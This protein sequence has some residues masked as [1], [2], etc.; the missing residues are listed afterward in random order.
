MDV[1]SQAI[2][3]LRYLTQVNLQTQWR[4]WVED[5]AFAAIAQAEDWCDRVTARSLKEPFA[6]LNV[7]GHIPWLKGQQSVWLSQQIAIPEH[8]HN[9]PLEGLEVRLALS[10]WAEVAEIFVDGQR[11]QEGDLFDCSTRIL[12]SAAAQPGDVFSVTLHLVSPG[13]DDGALVR[14]YLMFET[15]ATAT[16]LDPGFIADELA[17][18]QSYLAKFEPDRLPEMEQAISQIDWTRVCDRSAFDQSLS[19]LRRRLIPLANALKQRRIVML[20]HAHLDMA[21]LWPVAETWEAAERTFKSALGLQQDFPELIFC[22]S[23]P[24]LYAW[25]ENHRP[26]LFE[27][28]QQ[29]VKAGRWEIVAGLWVEPELNLIGGE[30]IV[31]QVLYGQRYVQQTFGQLNRIAWLPDTFGFCWQLPQI[32]KQGGVDF[33]VTQKLRW[34]DTT[35]FPY[36]AFWWQAPDGTAIFSL[37][38]A[39]IGQDISPI[40]MTDYAWEW[41]Q[42]TQL[43]DSLWL[44]GVGDHGGGPTRDMLETAQRWQRSPFFPQLEFATA[45]K[46]LQQI[47]TA[48]LP[49]AFPVWKD[50]LYLEFH[51]GCYTTHADQKRWNRHCE[52]LL[53][54]AELYAS[55]AHLITGQIYPKT[56]LEMAWKLVL[57][58]QFHDILP[59]SSIPQVFVDAN[60]DWEAA[61]QLASAI[62]EN[63]L[64]A[65]AAQIRVPELPHPEAQAIVVFNSLN[66]S[67]SEVVSLTLPTSAQ[68]WKIY[69]D[70]GQPVQT[71]FSIPERCPFMRSASATIE[72]GETWMEVSFLAHEIP[73]VG[74]RFFWLCPSAE[75]PDGDWK[76]P[77]DFGLENEFLQVVIDAQTGNL[78]R[79]FDKSAQRDVLNGAGNQLQAF[80]D[81]GQYWDAWNIDPNYAQHPLPAPQLEAIQWLEHGPLRQRIRVTHT[82]GASTFCQD[83]VLQVGAAVLK[84]ETAVDWQERHVVVKAAFPLNVDADYATYETPFAA[85]TRPA[86]PVEPQDKAKWEVPALQWA[87]LSCKD[88]GVSLLNDCKYGYD[89]S[90]TQLRLTLLRGAEWPDPDADR[91]AHQFTYALYPHAGSWQAA[92]TVRR[93]YEL[94]QPMPTVRS[95]LEERDRN[96]SLPT[97][98][99]LLN[100]QSENLILTAFKQSEDSSDQWILRCYEC[101]GEPTQL[102]V[103][104]DLKLVTKTPVDLL[105]QPIQLSDLQSNEDSVMVQPW[106]IMSLRLE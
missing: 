51:R 94:N 35:Q 64:R 93:G 3:Q 105:E 56:Q 27:A 24:A 104:S 84:I 72:G 47:Q 12:L 14:S 42:K 44:P 6:N 53:Y 19:Q 4:M 36:E 86:S 91:G 96:V 90:S 67:R 69:D 29:Q 45:E 23:T 21:W 99:Q 106:K 102:A 62:L 68:A 78:S 17:I 32:L 60:R 70:Q 11:V 85:I 20:G 13:H 18:L 61:N 22:H 41:E 58:N 16:D 40:K 63:S 54:Q 101:H 30:S 75:R 74:Y 80:Q 59:G 79:V 34:N 89:S 52:R 15:A 88:Y 71:Q 43:P 95:S 28:I 57:F 5:L 2:E 8:L 37:M 87:D 66:W 100:L 25:I 82:L 1:I 48:A 46:Y 33:F 65:I 55:L 98:G 10:W 92:Q 81:Q 9:Y 31:R 50:E 73:S 103:Q 7:K 38:S 83:Y 26:E 77:E 76:R 97:V 49:A 39:L